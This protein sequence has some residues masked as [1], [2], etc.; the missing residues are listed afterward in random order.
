MLKRTFMSA[1]NSGQHTSNVDLGWPRAKVLRWIFIEPLGMMSFSP[2]C[3]EHPWLG[4]T[5][6]KDVML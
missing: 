5:E 1:E 4:T 2:R 3:C 6:L